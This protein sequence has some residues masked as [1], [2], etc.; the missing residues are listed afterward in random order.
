MFAPI[1]HEQSLHKS[2]NSPKL[3]LQRRIE[4]FSDEQITRYLIKCC[5]HGLLG[6]SDEIEIQE[7]KDPIP[8]LPSNLL[9]SSS[10]VTVKNFEN[11]IDRYGLR[12]IA[13]APFMLK[14]IV[15]LLHSIAHSIAPPAP[16][17]I[18]E[19]NLSQAKS[20]TAYHLIE[21]FIDRA[22]TI[23]CST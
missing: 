17:N 6:T 14:I 12:E 16:T 11:M 21:Q 15:K 1:Q 4:P 7:G 22:H 19:K 5:F 2:S 8:E 23:Q 9:P 10:W 13:R 3:F 18:S 20:L